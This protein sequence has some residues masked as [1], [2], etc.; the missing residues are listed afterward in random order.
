MNE[1]KTASQITQLDRW[2]S[3]EFLI[4]GSGFHWTYM[5]YQFQ[6]ENKNKKKAAYA[7]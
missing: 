5:D 7:R 1:K 2:T 6:I 3:S 4:K